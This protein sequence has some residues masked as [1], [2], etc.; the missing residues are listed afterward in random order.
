M[1]LQW[2]KQSLSAWNG[3]IIKDKVPKKNKTTNSW[4]EYSEGNYE[5]LNNNFKEI[6]WKVD[7]QDRSTEQYYHRFC[8][9]TMKE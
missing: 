3:N 6:D 4:E 2:D 7:H 5:E 9:S 1:E 8:R